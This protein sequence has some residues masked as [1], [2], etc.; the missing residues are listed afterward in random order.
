[1]QATT[2][3]GETTADSSQ[4]E[5]LAFSA[6]NLN[7]IMLAL[8]SY[9]NSAGHFPTAYAGWGFDRETSEWYRHRRHLSWRVLLLPFLGEKELFDKFRLGQP[10][11]SEHNKKLISQMP[12]VYRAPGSRAG[13]GKTNYLGV[14]GPNAAFTTKKPTTIID[15]VDGTVQT[16]MVVETSDDAAVVWTRPSD[17]SADDEKPMDALVGLRDGGFLTVFADGATSFISEDAARDFL[18]SL[19]N[20]NDGEPLDDEQRQKWIRFVPPSSAKANDR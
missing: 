18:Q 1:L 15:M 6:R 4:N 8:H 13:A 10:W 20:R 11:D 19:F 5:Q 9:H 3:S 14:V 7:T 12:A 16:M 17:F 2:W